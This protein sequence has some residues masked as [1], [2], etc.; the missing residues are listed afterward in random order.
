M[1]RRLLVCAVAIAGMSI[2][3]QNSSPRSEFEVASI[4]AGDGGMAP[5]IQASGSQVTIS[6]GLRALINKAYHAQFISGAQPGLLTTFYIR[7]KMPEGTTKY[8]IPEM[9]RS[10]LEDRFGLSVHWEKQAKKVYALRV[11]GAAKLTRSEGLDDS[12]PGFELGA[13][14]S[15]FARL[16]APNGG[17][18][19][20]K[21]TADGGSKMESKGGSLGYFTEI[22][23]RLLDRPVVDRTGLSG[24][25]DFTLTL[26][27]DDMGRSNM[28][29]T[30]DPARAVNT[31]S[32]RDSLK[33]LG[34]KLEKAD[35]QVDVL[36]IDH[37]DPVPTDN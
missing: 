36:V 13:S 14:P 33:A 20:S 3:E 6:L 16:S 7:A 22:F 35:E 28:G 8:M 17:I 1:V 9:L 4:R 12:L 31:P 25:F 11:D 37:V 27:A 23:S 2:A 34:L 29:Q 24:Y 32:L 21:P 15:G 26:S 18:I 19:S 10:L 30:T 5:G